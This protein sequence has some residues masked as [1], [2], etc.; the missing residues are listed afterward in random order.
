MFLKTTE[1]LKI[2]LL[3]VIIIMISISETE[4]MIISMTEVVIKLI[5]RR[6]AGKRKK[7]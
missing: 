7:P 4:R 6:K 3:I 2:I 5:L 1:N